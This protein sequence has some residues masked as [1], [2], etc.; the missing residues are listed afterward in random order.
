MIDNRQ[1]RAENEQEVADQ[2]L[3]IWVQPPC[4]CSWGLSPG[5]ALNGSCL[6]PGKLWKKSVAMCGL[7]LWKSK[8]SD[9]IGLQSENNFDRICHIWILFWLQY[10][11]FINCF[12]RLIARLI[13]VLHRHLWKCVQLQLEARQQS[14]KINCK[15]KVHVCCD[16][17]SWSHLLVC[18]LF[19][20]ET[21][22]GHWHHSHVLQ[23]SGKLRLQVFP[24]FLWNSQYSNSKVFAQLI[25]TNW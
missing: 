6:V 16:V 1:L 7:S 21:Q 3:A 9:L 12:T 2:D 19:A 25:P 17:N 22:A 24:H 4:H 15:F 14:V 11:T 8:V 20:I 5:I 18:F 23:P 10:C 13:A